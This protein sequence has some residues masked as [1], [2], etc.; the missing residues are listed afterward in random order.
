[1]ALNGSD[2]GSEEMNETREQKR[3]RVIAA[4]EFRRPDRMPVRGGCGSEAALAAV[5]G[6]SDYRQSP[7]DV[8]REA[9]AVWNV[10]LITQFVLPGRLDRQCGPLAE[11]DV[12]ALRNS[13][14]AMISD[15]K[16]SNGEFTSPEDFRDFCLQVP[17]VHEA[18]RRVDAVRVRDQWLALDAWGD[19]LSPMAWVPGHLAGTVAWMYYTSVGYEPYLMAHELYPEAVQ[20]LFAFTGEEARCK[21]IA[22]AAAIREHDLIPL[23]YSGEDICGNS[24][25]MCGPETLRQVYFPH[26]KHALEPM[27]DA[28]IHWMWHSDGNI[29]P[30]VDDLV[31]C[32][33]DG[34]QGFEEDKGMDLDLLLRHRGRDGSPPF[35]CGSISVTTTIYEGV[36]AVRRDKERMRRIHERQGGGVILA[37]SSSIMDNTPVDCVRALYEDNA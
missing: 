10:D 19:F 35:I 24:G 17:D 29:N 3:E 28:G 2:T 37:S 27:F 26:L 9:H 34:F 22:I 25:P 36:E 18:A 13:A 11:C 1:M 12:S 31:A 23:I 15:W 33:I 8:Y 6:R 14:Y 21:N 16:E 30:I 4:V 5:T 20:R 32:G 7:K